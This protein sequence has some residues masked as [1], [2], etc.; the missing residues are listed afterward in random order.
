MRLT[1]YVPTSFWKVHTELANQ[2]EDM[3]L[4]EAFKLIAEEPEANAGATDKELL[5]VQGSL[6]TW[7]LLLPNDENHQGHALIGLQ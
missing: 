4:A 6:L 5:E 3:E 2:T 1:T 7:G